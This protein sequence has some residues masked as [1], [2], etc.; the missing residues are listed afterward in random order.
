MAFYLGMSLAKLV[1]IDMT[2][3]MQTVTSPMCHT[4]VMVGTVIVSFL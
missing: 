4:N 2:S 1:V 3:N